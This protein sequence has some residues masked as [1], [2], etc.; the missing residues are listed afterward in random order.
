MRWKCLIKPKN[1]QL[2]LGTRRFKEMSTDL[3]GA[4]STRFQLGTDVRYRYVPKYN[5]F[6]VFLRI[7]VYWKELA[8]SKSLQQRVN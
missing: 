3:S 2:I 8:S 6:H 1:D 4:P 7:A 5:A